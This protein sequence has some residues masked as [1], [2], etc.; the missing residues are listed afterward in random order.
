MDWK[1]SC[2]VRREL[3]QL[4]KAKRASW[5]LRPKSCKLTF[6]IPLGDWRIH[7][8]NIFTDDNFHFADL[9][10]TDEICDKSNL[11][12]L[13]CLFSAHE[14]EIA[15]FNMARN[16]ASSVNTLRVEHIRDTYN[17]LER[18]WLFFNNLKSM[19]MHVIVKRAEL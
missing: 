4:S 6:R 3:I 1:V 18:Y 11:D 10:W 9:E 8:S 19:M 15:L 13:N 14:I 12:H 16:K 17:L 2:A 7:L 5:L